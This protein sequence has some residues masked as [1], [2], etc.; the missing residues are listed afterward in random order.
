MKHGRL[1]STTTT[2]PKVC[3]INIYIQ[4]IKIIPTYY[5]CHSSLNCTTSRICFYMSHGQAPPSAW[6]DWLKKFTV[7]QF[8]ACDWPSETSLNDVHLSC[9]ADWTVKS[10]TVNDWTAVLGVFYGCL[11]STT[12]SYFLYLRVLGVFRGRE[13]E[14]TA[15]YSARSAV[16]TKCTRL[17]FNC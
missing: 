11:L 8:S 16:K 4:Y 7:F 17:T 2:F 9:S 13:N 5:S 6:P 1:L 10:E 12:S 14:T 15:F 3:K